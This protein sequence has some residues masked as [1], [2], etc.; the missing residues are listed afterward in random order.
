MCAINNNCRIR[1]IYHQQAYPLVAAAPPSS[2]V[3]ATCSPPKETSSSPLEAST[4]SPPI[5]AT[6]SPPVASSGPHPLASTVSHPVVAA[7]SPLEV[8]MGLLPLTTSFSIRL[9]VL[10]FGLLFTPL[11]PPSPDPRP[12]AMF[13]NIVSQQDNLP[14]FLSRVRTL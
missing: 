14:I 1:V 5:T 12:P 13:K 4:G 6:V 11:P 10:L 2:L 9:V 7:G 3:E 8:S